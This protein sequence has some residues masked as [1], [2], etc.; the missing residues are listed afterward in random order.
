M[1]EESKKMYIKI[2]TFLTVYMPKQRGL[3]EC[4]SN[5]L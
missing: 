4:T 2:R 3:S 5:I 1:T